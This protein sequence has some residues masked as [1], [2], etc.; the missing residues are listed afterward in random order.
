MKTEPVLQFTGLVC[1]WRLYTVLFTLAI[2]ME[3]IRGKNNPSRLISV[4]N[5]SFKAKWVTTMGSTEHQYRAK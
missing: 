1:V 5:D 4:A 2:L 3:E